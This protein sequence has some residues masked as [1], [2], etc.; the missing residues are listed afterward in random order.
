[1]NSPDKFIAV[2]AVADTPADVVLGLTSSGPT[3][4][5]AAF[6]SL[7]VLL[8]QDR[9]SQARGKRKFFAA[10][11]ALVAA[12]AAVFWWFNSDKPVASKW[13]NETVREVRLNSTSLVA[14][15]NDSKRLTV[16]P[17]ES[18]LKREPRRSSPDE[19][20]LLEVY[21]LLAS[22][23]GDQALQKAQRLAA[24]A[25]GFALA[26]LLYADLLT[27]QAQ[28]AAGFGA[29]ASEVV[30]AGRERLDELTDEARVR[31]QA[32]SVMPAAGLVPSALVTLAPNVK[33]A[34][35]VDVARSR[36]YVFENGSQGLSLIREYYASIGKNGM[37]K[38]VAGDQRTP[39]GVYFVTKQIPS[40][41]LPAKYG[42]QALALNYPNPYDRLQGRGGDGIWL[43]GIPT[44]MYSRAPWATDGCIALANH[45]LQELS[46]YIDVQATPIIV[47]ERL[48]WVKPGE[49]TTR[50]AD[51][52]G[53]FEKWQTARKQ[54]NAEARDAF[55]STSVNLPDAEAL[56]PPWREQLR[57]EQQR[58]AR[59]TAANPG[60]VQTAPDHL[61]I[62]SW[63][64]R[65]AVM[66]VTFTESEPGDKRPRTRRQY[67][68]QEP[69]GW[70]IFY[71][72]SL[73]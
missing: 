65:D 16:V 4:E 61:S 10:L 54:N 62:V 17:P 28:P 27:A 2:H 68:I 37:V 56:G 38:Q 52:L 6:S 42:K 48:E 32:A 22:G 71:E 1:M 23:D 36:L 25:P 8:D 67:W 53:V 60:A 18:L 55:Y 45:Y 49:L 72:R 44:G 34:V 50:H 43:H 70:R 63:Q 7:N 47:A 5:P 29:A 26:Q 3:V 15:G 40:A 46:A 20:R 14:S 41:T 73:V 33:H 58:R 51:F 59:R 31:V 57:E 30:S 39:L 11:A 12:G 64:D 35:A 66:V 69:A 13:V 19:A 21:G 24:D 9:A